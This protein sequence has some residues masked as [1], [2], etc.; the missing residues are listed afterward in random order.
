MI[1][2]SVVAVEN[3][4]GRL[5]VSRYRSSQ[6]QAPAVPR[7]YRGWS[8]IGDNTGEVSLENAPATLMLSNAG[9]RPL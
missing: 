5:Y 4:C 6:I 2:V 3:A 1:E 7:L 9:N 8:T